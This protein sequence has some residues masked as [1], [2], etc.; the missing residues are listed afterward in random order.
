MSARP[1][2]A[3]ELVAAAGGDRFI[4]SELD[5]ASSFRAYA[6]GAAAGWSGSRDPKRS[7]W[8][9]VTGDPSAAASLVA[10]MEQ[11]RRD[12]GEAAPVGMTL[13]R[14][15]WALL[16]SRPHVTR[17]ADW[18]WMWTDEPPP[19]QP[20]EAAVDWIHAEA[21]EIR[22]LLR[23][24]SPRWSV[25]PAD[26]HVVRWCGIRDADGSLVATAVHAAHGPGVPH[27]ASIATRPDRRGAGLGAAVTAW[28]TRRLLEDHPWVT[29][30]MYADNDTARRMYRRLGWRCDHRFTSGA[31]SPASSTP[32]S[33][34]P[35]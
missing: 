5:P 19:E 24:A 29:L 31:R 18:D 28:I 27:L 17:S 33:E 15:A 11:D 21:D 32:G 7:S 22:D 34:A 9:T 1:Q 12:A 20:G 14:G 3:R 8:L 10:V 16:A 13:T 25:D 23:A 2:S 4:A 35:T 6:N 26:S 30:G